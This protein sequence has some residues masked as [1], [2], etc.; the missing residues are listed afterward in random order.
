M[1]DEV[2]TGRTGGVVGALDMLRHALADPLSAAGL[3]L[4]LLERRL[5]ALPVDGS[6]AAKVRGAKSDLAAAGRLIDLL[7][8]LARVARESPEDTSLEE[9]CEAAGIA[10]EER[11]EALPRFLLRRRTTIDAVRAASELFRSPDASAAPP[12]GRA[13]VLAETVSVRIVGGGGRG[14][15]SPERLFQLPRD[16]ERAG[17]LFLARAGVETDGGTLRLVEEE[18]RLVAFFSWPR[19]VTATGRGAPE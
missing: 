15:A 14:P 5:V 16:E 12:L 2:P 9:I 18:G 1:D 13:E 6:L 19:P 8:R 10:L 4:E 3:K 17:E 7:P 11:S